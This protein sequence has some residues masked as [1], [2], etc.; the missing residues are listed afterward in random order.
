MSRTPSKKLVAK[1]RLFALRLSG[2]IEP[3]GETSAAK[4]TPSEVE[5]M[6]VGFERKFPPKVLGIL[7][8]FVVVVVMDF[9]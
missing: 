6:F 7:C 9:L 2:L 3:V 1:R 8:L 5:L 4:K